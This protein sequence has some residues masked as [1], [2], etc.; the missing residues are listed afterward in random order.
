MTISIIDSNRN[1]SRTNKTAGV[2]KSQ[3]TTCTGFIRNQDAMFNLTNERARMAP[4]HRSVSA[5]GYAGS[6][7]A[8]ILYDY[9]GTQGLGLLENIV[10]VN[11]GTSTIYAY[12]NNSEGL[13]SA[14]AAVNFGSGFLPLASGES[15]ELHGQFNHIGIFDPSGGNSLVQMYGNVLFNRNTI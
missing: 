2:Y 8:T 14:A 4:D 12:I 13:A 11:R 6:G 5:T 1:P 15:I 3:G 10:V 7:S 9:D